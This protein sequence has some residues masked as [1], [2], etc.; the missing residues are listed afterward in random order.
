MNTTIGVSKD[1]K[2]RL[3]EFKNFVMPN[4]TDSDFVSWLISSNPKIIEMLQKEEENRWLKEFAEQNAVNPNISWE[5][6][7]LNKME[8]KLNG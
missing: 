5:D 6:F 7:K 1:V 8:V 3:K 4:A 2:I